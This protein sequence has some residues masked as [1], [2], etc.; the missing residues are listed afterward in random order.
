MKLITYFAAIIWITAAVVPFA[1]AADSSPSRTQIKLLTPFSFGRISN[2]LNAAEKASGTCFTESVAS[3][4]RPDAWRC[5]AGNAIMDP[6]F[7]N[8]MGDPKVLACTRDPWGNNVVLLSLTAPLPNDRRKE[9]DRNATLPWALELV[10][11][12][13]CSLFTGATAPIAG[14]RINYGCPGGWNI[15]GDIDRSQP[16]WRVFAQAESSSVL[17][18]VDIAVAWY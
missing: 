8:L 11:G 7:Q 17:E 10:T 13:H 12:Q 14:M 6:C 5:M 2:G 15:V 3:S 9:V 16:V 4:S 1:M 18:Q